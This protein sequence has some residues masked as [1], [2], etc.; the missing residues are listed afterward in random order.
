M[1][2]ESHMN[3]L[4]VLLSG[5]SSSFCNVTN[6][7][8]PFSSENAK[9]WE[10]QVHWKPAWSLSKVFGKTVSLWLPNGRLFPYNLEDLKTVKIKRKIESTSL[11]TLM[12]NSYMSL[13][14]LTF[15]S[16]FQTWKTSTWVFCWIC[17]S[18]VS[19]GSWDIGFMFNHFANAFC[20]GDIFDNVIGRSLNE[21]NYSTELAESQVYNRLFWSS[22]KM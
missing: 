13:K 17:D 18:D 2:S 14:Y 6:L 1:L 11:K 8:L 3:E 22:L 9:T 20:Q 15:F 7:T 4:N 21:L 12:R 10:F 5:V 19:P 16:R